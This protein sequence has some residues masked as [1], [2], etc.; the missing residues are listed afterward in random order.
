MA[1]I[2]SPSSL[3]AL[4]DVEI[5]LP[6]DPLY[7][8]RERSYHAANARLAPSCIARP[9]SAPQVASLL[10]ELAASKTEFAVRG[11][12]HSPVPGASDIA[13]GGVTVELGL[14]NKVTYDA[15]GETVRF[16][17]GARWR[18][19][20]GELAKYQRAVPG[21]RSGGVG[22][23]GLLLGGGSSW[24][25][26][27]HGWACD[28]VMSF[29]VVLGDGRIVTADKDTH[30]D[31]FRALKGG[32]NNFGIATSFVNRTHSSDRIWGG[33]AANPESA[34]GQILRAVRNFTQRQGQGEARDS[35]LM[36]VFGYF[37]DF[38]ANVGSTAV[39]QAGSNPSGPE[40]E[41]WRALPKIVD[42]TK[43]TTMAALA[44]EITLPA[45]YH[46]AWF[47]LCIK[48]DEKIM[49]KATDA[50]ETLVAELK[51]Y[52]SDGN[53]ITNCI[54]QPVPR[55]V[56]QRTAA[57]GGNIMGT[58][59]IAEDAVLF[60]LAVMTETAEQARWAHPKLQR[61]VDALRDFAAEKEVEGGGG[62]MDWVYMNYADASQDVIGSY[63]A[64]NVE[65]MRRVAVKYD[66]ELVFQK[67]C[68]GG[69]KI[70]GL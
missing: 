16:G 35:Y 10:R 21:G 53:F 12:G 45:N 67:L 39:F 63:G 54:F 22:V 41:E 33:I 27:K 24:Q 4:A 50:H 6:A 58:E 43:E 49:K 11:G 55:T 2:L 30:A 42:M 62:L 47:T 3:K 8:I 48:N 70:P 9:T 51:S 31:L 37:P 5:L 32:A 66:P 23:S 19:V 40:F 7:G 52:I 64:E 36:A 26:A 28:N 1:D 15:A 18:D 46:D 68:P 29:E 13:S 65:K 56:S 44:E 14:L 60:Q 61:C 34:T 17:A 38:G 20:Y 59:R 25:V 57:A 69:W